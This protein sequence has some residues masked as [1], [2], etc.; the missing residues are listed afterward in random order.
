MLTFKLV[1]PVSVIKTLIHSTVF[2]AIHA[3]ESD[4]LI[5]TYL[6]YLEV[7]AVKHFQERLVALD[8]ITLL[9]KTIDKLDTKILQPLTRESDRSKLFYYRSGRDIALRAHTTLQPIILTTC[10]SEPTRS[11]GFNLFNGYTTPLYYPYHYTVVK[12]HYPTIGRKAL[13][14]YF[15]IPALTSYEVRSNIRDV[16][17][18]TPTDQ[19]DAI[20]ERVI[21]TIKTLCTLPVFLCDVD[22]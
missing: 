8:L 11:M 19:Q 15:L 16:L 4:E 22:L 9:K 10:S 20:I 3:T 14:E 6:P 5:K 18:K 7:T 13:L 21:E 17:I 1:L 2:Y 12:G